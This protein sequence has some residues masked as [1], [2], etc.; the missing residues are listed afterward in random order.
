MRPFSFGAESECRIPQLRWLFALRPSLLTLSPPA[1][2]F[3][4]TSPLPSV[5]CRDALKIRGRQESRAIRG[6]RSLRRILRSRHSYVHVQQVRAGVPSSPSLLPEG[7]GSEPS[8][9]RAILFTW[10]EGV[11]PAHL[12]CAG[13]RE[14]REAQDVRERPLATFALCRCAV[15]ASRQSPGQTSCLPVRRNAAHP[16]AAELVRSRGRSIGR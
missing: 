12:C 15:P 7:E 14:C 4:P 11:A 9:L 10:G 3:S 6:Q 2:R 13:T 1:W 16:C 8:A 5:T